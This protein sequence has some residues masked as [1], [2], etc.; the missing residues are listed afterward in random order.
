[1]LWIGLISGT[2]ADGVDAGLAEIGLE[3][4]K[5]PKFLGARSYRCHPFPADV[6]K[7]ILEMAETP[8]INAEELLHLDCLLGEIFAAAA[9]ELCQAAGVR[10]QDVR[11]IGSHGQTIRHLPLRREERLEFAGAP[12]KWRTASTLQIGDSSIIAERT[13]IATIG[14]FRHRDMAAGGQGAPLVPIFHLALLGALPG[15]RNARTAAVN[16]G[17]IANV[18]IPPGGGHPALAF[19]TGP[20]NM[21]LDRLCSTFWPDGPGYDQGGGHAAKGCVSGEL[22]KEQLADP[23][24][25]LAP[26][27]STGRELFGKAFTE[28]FSRKAARLRLSPEDTL[29]TATALTAAS[30]AEA[31]QAHAGPLDRLFICGGGAGNATLLSMIRD[32]MPKAAVEP[33]TAL[34]VDPGAVEAHA[35]AYLAAC[36]EA[37]WPGNIAAATGARGAVVLGERAPGRSIP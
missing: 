19:D 23:Y 13:G 16:I 4:A 3:P 15:S 24:F 18:T 7:R 2:S 9:L 33:T 37:L 30:I 10:P 25:S 32:R 35:F 22:L 14:R 17:G 5:A 36:H 34:G 6:R 28:E 8:D 26:P 20:G 31:L 29:A 11:A 1:M 12:R 27:K 21:V